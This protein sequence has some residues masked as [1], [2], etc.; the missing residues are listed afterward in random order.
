MIYLAWQA[1]NSG[2][3]YAMAEDIEG[4]TDEQEDQIFFGKPVPAP[5]PKVQIKLLSPGRV[6]DVIGTPSATRLVSASLKGVMESFCPDCVQYIPITV[7]RMATS[8]D[9]F[10]ANIV[11]HTEAMDMIQSVYQTFEDSPDVIYQ[12]TNLV[13]KPL[14]KD[15]PPIF[16]LKEVPAII[17]V[18]DDLREGIQQV[19]RAA[20]NFIPIDEYRFG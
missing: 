16:H 9:Y 17:L 4:W 12:I 19:S 1:Y 7:P 20:G 8:K 5:L 11:K 10:I 13:L 3:S 6:A 14:G 15:S 2:S 18:R